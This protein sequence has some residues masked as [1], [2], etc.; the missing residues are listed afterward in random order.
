MGYTMSKG[1]GT[2]ILIQDPHFLW[3]FPDSWTMAEAATVPVCY[4]TVYYAL[5]VRGKMREGETVL[6]HAGSG[7]VGQA[8]IHVALNRGCKVFTT[9]GSQEKRDFLK[10][11]FPSLTDDMIGNS[12]DC[13]FEDMVMKQT[14]GRGVDI[15]LNSLA[16]DK[17]RASVRCLADFGRF[18]E[19]GKYDIVQNHPLGN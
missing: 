12:R 18:L 3:D 16:E 7:G 2:S 11:T 19:I 13:S 6:I 5:I 9:V 15:V 8:A 4:L 17:F 10:K 14:D 1:I